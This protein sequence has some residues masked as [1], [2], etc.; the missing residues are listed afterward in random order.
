MVE[1]LFGRKAIFSAAE[2]VTK[3]PPNNLVELLSS[4]VCLKTAK[5]VLIPFTSGAMLKVSFA[6]KITTALPSR[7]SASYQPDHSMALW[8]ALRLLPEPSFH[9]R[10]L[11]PS[12]MVSTEES[13]SRL[14]ASYHSFMPVIDSLN[15]L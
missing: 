5:T 9:M 8:P 13:A 1:S 4:E 10:T 15:R 6:S 2:V 3:S 7:P 12:A 14:A 11:L